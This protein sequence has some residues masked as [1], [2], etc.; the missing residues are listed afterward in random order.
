MCRLLCSARF[1]AMSGAAAR[2]SAE[3]RGLGEAVRRR[4][5]A[6]RLQWGRGFL[7]QGRCEAALSTATTFPLGGFR[8]SQASGA[9]RLATIEDIG[10]GDIERFQQ[11]SSL[12]TV[13]QS[14]DPSGQIRQNHGEGIGVIDGDEEKSAEAEEINFGVS[15]FIARVR[16][17]PEPPPGVEE[18]ARVQE[19]YYVF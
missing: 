19:V 15:T 1:G 17:P 3:V 2:S 9:A 8:F 6:T 4:C 16:P 11:I 10:F 14:S 18:G 12:G 5:E 7:Q 13:A